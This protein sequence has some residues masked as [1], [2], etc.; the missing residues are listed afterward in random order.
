[1]SPDVILRPYNHAELAQ[2]Y[3]IS[4]KTLQ[5][6]L[7]PHKYTIGEKTGHF[8]NTKQVEIIFGLL[9][10]PFKKAE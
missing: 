6:W 7:A 8:Y 10:F 5:K 3:G 1:M 9:G 2:L 4:W